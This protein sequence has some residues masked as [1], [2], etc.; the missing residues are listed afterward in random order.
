M[1][2][3]DQFRRRL[4]GL[5]GKL[6][7]LAGNNDDEVLH[8]ARAAS[9]MLRGADLRLTDLGVAVDG[10][11]RLL[12]SGKLLDA[13]RALKAE[14]DSLAIE[15]AHLKRQTANG[16]ANGFA[17][18]LWQS[19][20]TVSNK[21]TR[22]LLDLEAQGLVSLRGKEPDFSRNCAGWRGSLTSPQQTWLQDIT[23]RAV[24]QTGMTP[25]A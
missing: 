19:T 20:G 24:A 2:K 17:A 15:N 11:G 1:G 3:E 4:V 9:A 21:T 25:P 16:E 14:R 23:E 12:D 10:E 13:A 22:W 8:A 6:D 5:L 18:Q 7:P